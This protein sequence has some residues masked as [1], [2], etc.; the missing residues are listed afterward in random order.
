MPRHCAGRQVPEMSK[1]TEVGYS[2]APASTQFPKG[3]SGNPKGRPK[4]RHNRPPYDAILGQMVTIKQDGV[5]RLVTAAEAFILYMSKWGLDGDVA[6]A[7]STMAA[8][9]EARSAST[10]NGYSEIQI[11]M[12]P[13]APGNVNIALSL[14]GWQQSSITIGRVPG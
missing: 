13:V 11:V 9:E 8:I 6:V 12:R 2:I 14:C 7:R 1:G 5:E 10:A 3:R 4:G